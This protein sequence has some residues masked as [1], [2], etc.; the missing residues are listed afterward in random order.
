MPGGG[1]PRLPRPGEGLRG[2]LLSPGR[3]P[4][5]MPPLPGPRIPRCIPAE[6]ADKRP[7]H[8][9]VGFSCHVR[10][11]SGCGMLESE[12]GWPQSTKVGQE[13]QR[14]SGQQAV[15]QTAPTVDTAAARSRRGLWQTQNSNGHRN[16][17]GQRATSDCTPR[18]VPESLAQ[19]QGG[20]TRTGAVGVPFPAQRLAAVATD[21]SQ[22]TSL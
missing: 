18:T 3:P 6:P 19:Q 8:G 17:Q 4:Y 22:S 5:P 12:Q 10:P 2:R 9:H 1:E 21:R 14:S 16:W 7:G 13:V 15:T 20:N 11:Q